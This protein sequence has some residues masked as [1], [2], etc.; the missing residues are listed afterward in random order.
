MAIAGVAW[1]CGSDAVEDLGDAMVDAGVALRDAASDAAAAQ[2]AAEC[3]IDEG[4]TLFAE[5]A[6]DVD[7]ATVTDARA[8]LCDLEGTAPFG[9]GGLDCTSGTVRFDAT[10]ARVQCGSGDP[11]GSGYRWRSVRIFIE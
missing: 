7:P 11:T 8:I 9:L 6:I 5:A 1:A 4:G 2:V 10:R 3:T